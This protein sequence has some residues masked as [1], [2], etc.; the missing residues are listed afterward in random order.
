MRVLELLNRFVCCLRLC[1]RLNILLVSFRAAILIACFNLSSCLAYRVCNSLYCFFVGI[2][3][4]QFIYSIIN[5]FRLN[6]LYFSFVIS[7]SLGF[8]K[9][10]SV[11]VVLKALLI[12]RKTLL[13]SS[14]TF[15]ISLFTVE[16]GLF[17]VLESSK[18][19]TELVEV[20]SGDPVLLLPVTSGT[21]YVRN[22]HTAGYQ[23]DQRYYSEYCAERFYTSVH[24]VPSL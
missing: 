19:V 18:T 20:L 9:R 22:C 12:G 5:L 6:L 17:V 3:I 14:Q 4:H 1:K 15:F 16:V 2:P 11:S 13:V 23:S 24:F 21:E 7:S 10:F 8:K